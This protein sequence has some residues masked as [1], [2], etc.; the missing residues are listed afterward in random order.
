VKQNKD[1]GPR[2]AR[3]IDVLLLLVVVLFAV[4][5]VAASLGVWMLYV[6]HAE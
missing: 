5:C 6:L 3:R 2:A 1:R 4:A